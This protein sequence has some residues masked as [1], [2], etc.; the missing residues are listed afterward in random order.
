MSQG[1]PKEDNDP[2]AEGCPICDAPMRRVVACD[3][4]SMVIQNGA[5][6]LLAPHGHVARWRTLC[7]VFRTTA[8]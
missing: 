5:G 7:P 6:L 2:G 8:P 4:Q 1:C 3:A